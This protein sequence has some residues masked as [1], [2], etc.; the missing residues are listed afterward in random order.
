MRSYS[1]RASD[2][3]SRLTCFTL[4]NLNHI[5]SCGKK[6]V[7]IMLCQEWREISLTALLV[8]CHDVTDRIFDW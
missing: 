4:M 8:N 2:K 6:V 1:D 7:D 5:N 3:V